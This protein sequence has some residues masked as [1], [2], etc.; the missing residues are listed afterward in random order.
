MSADEAKTE[1]LSGARGSEEGVR[2]AQKAM[3]RRTNFDN[4]SVRPATKAMPRLRAEVRKDVLQEDSQSSRRDV[5]KGKGK[6][7]KGNREDRRTRGR[8]QRRA[9]WED[10][11]RSDELRLHGEKRK[12]HHR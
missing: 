7:A 9:S 1:Q 3:P 2:P 5:S 4:D 8:W 10:G 12:Y 11:T 6:N